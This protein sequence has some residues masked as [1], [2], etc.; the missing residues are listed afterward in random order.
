MPSLTDL[1]SLVYTLLEER[2]RLA[3][4]SAPAQIDPNF[5]L[6]ESGVLDS[7]AFGELMAGLAGRLGVTLDFS[8]LPTNRIAN[9]TYFCSYVRDAVA[10]QEGQ[11]GA[12]A[13]SPGGTRP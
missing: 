7:L 12:A 11:E 8:D 2:F 13:K 9:F 3:G 5:D 6:F 10:G 4:V 1:Q